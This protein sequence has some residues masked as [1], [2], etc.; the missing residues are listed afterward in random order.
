MD[1]KVSPETEVHEKPVKIDQRSQCH[2]AITDLHAVA[3]H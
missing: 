3:D 1:V 2:H